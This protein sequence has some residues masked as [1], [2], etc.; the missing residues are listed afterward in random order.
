MCV[1]IV[2]GTLQLR[3]NKWRIYGKYVIISVTV[4]ASGPVFIYD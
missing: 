3:L 1:R 4:H 2:H